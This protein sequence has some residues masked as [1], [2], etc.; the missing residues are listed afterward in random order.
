MLQMTLYKWY[1]LKYRQGRQTCLTP[2]AAC[3]GV[4]V[5][6][7]TCNDKTDYANGNLTTSDLRVCGN[8]EYSKVVLRFEELE[9]IP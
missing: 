4:M 9:E 7:G 8:M 2:R 1:N 6:Y 5:S 3:K